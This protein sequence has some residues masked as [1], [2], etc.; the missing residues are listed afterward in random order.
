MDLLAGYEDDYDSENE[1]PQPTYEGMEEEAIEERGE[2]S[3]SPPAVKAKVME[4]KTIQSESDDDS[5]SD[6]EFGPKPTSTHGALPAPV[7]DMDAYIEKYKIPLAKEISLAGASKAV[8]CVSVEP[9]GNRVVTGCLDYYIRLYDFGGM[10]SRHVSFKSVEVQEGHPIVA[11]SHSPSG[12]KFAV[13][14]SSAQPKV[15]D[16]D[17]AELAQLIKG[18]M[19]I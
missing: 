18:D 6:D 16:R 4:P 1:K 3:N 14:T 8:T 7:V 15:F 19:Y 11:I 13:A 2:P 10:D 17:G 12:D 5:S 9:S